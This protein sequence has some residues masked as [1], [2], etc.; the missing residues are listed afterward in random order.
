MKLSDRLAKHGFKN[1]PSPDPERDNPKLKVYTNGQMYVGF[2]KIGN[3]FRVDVQPLF[4]GIIPGEK[5]LDN[6]IVPK[7]QLATFVDSLMPQLTQS[8]EEV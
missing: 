5:A 6:Q 7:D 1:V 3:V 8:A 2:Q 4:M